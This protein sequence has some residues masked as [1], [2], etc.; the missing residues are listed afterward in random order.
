MVATTYYNK[1]KT[2]F[3]FSAF[4]QLQR[5]HACAIYQLMWACSSAGLF[6]RQNFNRQ[7]RF[8]ANLPNFLSTKIFSYAVFWRSS[9]WWVF[10]ASTK[11][12]S[13]LIFHAIWYIYICRW[14]LNPERNGLFHPVLFWI[15]C[16][17][18]IQYPS[19]HTKNF[20]LGIRNPKSNIFVLIT[21]ETFLLITRK[22][23]SVPFQILVTARYMQCYFL[24]LTT[25]LIFY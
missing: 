19:I 15:I 3:V 7:N 17:E 11:F 1:T 23:R 24:T 25:V 5:T 16:P 20:N 12:N 21:I 13:L 9:S 2:H 4:S 18:A 10:R 8:L 14:L 22:L 6:I